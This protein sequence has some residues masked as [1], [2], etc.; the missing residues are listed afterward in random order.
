MELTFHLIPQ[1]RILFSGT[2]RFQKVQLLLGIQ[3]ATTRL[4]LAAQ[5]SRPD[6]ST[7]DATRQRLHI[8]LKLQ[9]IIPRQLPVQWTLDDE[10]GGVVPGMTTP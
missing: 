1:Q 8:Q 4:T 5:G 7:S 6:E 3:P 10:T 2:L 9:S